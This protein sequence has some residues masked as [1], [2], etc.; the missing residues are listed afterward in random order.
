[1]PKLNFRT[2]GDTSG[3][4]QRLLGKLEDAGTV[5]PVAQLLAN[6]ENGFRPY[7]LMSAALLR[8]GTLPDRLREVAILAVATELDAAYEWKEPAIMSAAVGV[9]DEQRDAIRAGRLTADCFDEDEREAMRLALLILQGGFALDEWTV[10]AE[11]WG[12]AS[13]LDLIFIVGWWGGF[14]HLVIAALED[15]GLQT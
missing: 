12:E 6:S 7:V 13:V 8:Q 4:V 15:Q 9:T 2:A 11:R 5:L 14:M 1:M 10:A 3:D